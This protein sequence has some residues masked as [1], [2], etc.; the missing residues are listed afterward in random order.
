MS[1]LFKSLSFYIKGMN[2]HTLRNQICDYLSTNTSIFDNIDVNQIT[3]WESNM[4]YLE[5]VSNMRKETTWGGS[6][7]IKCFCNIFN[8][9]VVVHH[10]NRQ[11]EFLPNTSNPIGKIN[12][13][14][15]GNHYFNI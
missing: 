2:E 9:V 3:G 14:Y 1:C 15:T 11:I 7:E 13:G 8:I 12:I 10:R 4:N 5:Y 6:L